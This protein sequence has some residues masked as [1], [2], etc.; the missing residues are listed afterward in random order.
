MRQSL[1]TALYLLK[2]ESITS[3]I[4]DFAFFGQEKY[5]IASDRPGS[6]NIKNIGWVTH[7]SEL[8]S[9][10]GPFANLGEKVFDDYWMFYLTKDMARA[11]ELP[12]R[13][14]TNLESYLQYRGVDR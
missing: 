3:V 2:L 4:N 14:Y 8:I 12:K 10:D 13:P 1:S 9:G 7:V 6:G 5:R 11:A